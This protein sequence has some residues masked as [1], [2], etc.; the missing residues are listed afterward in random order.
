MT[1]SEQDEIEILAKARRGLS[2]RAGDAA[3]VLSAIGPRLADS[4]G[5]SPQGSATG[6]GASATLLRSRPSW[7]TVGALS[8]VVA[9]SA[10]ATG[11]YLGQAN[12]RASTAPHERSR[13]APPAGPA[14]EPSARD[15]RDEA[16]AIP[17]PAL[18]PTPELPA[19]SNPA[20]PQRSSVAPAPSGDSE[21]EMETRMLAR[22]ERS[23]REDNPRLALG[24]LGELDRNVPGGQLREEREAARVMAHCALGSETARTRAANFAQSHPASSYLG[25]IRETCQLPAPELVHDKVNE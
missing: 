25:R 17:A 6:A 10:G 13:V 22:V 9:A 7:L 8:A 19:A 18:Q 14:P 3:R 20:S 24:L 23:L 4:P 11:Y 12:G 5:S 15:L 1:V 21:L 16:P 2:P